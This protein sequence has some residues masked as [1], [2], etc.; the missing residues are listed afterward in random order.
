MKNMKLRKEDQSFLCVTHCLD[1]IYISIE[2]HEDSLKNVYGWTD[3]AMLLNGRIKKQVM[4]LTQ[5]YA[6]DI[7]D[8]TQMWNKPSR[9]K[10][11]VLNQS[12]P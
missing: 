9:H 10:T 5:L 3:S 6:M 11:Q 1:Q 7:C 8:N 2:Y 12:G 4:C